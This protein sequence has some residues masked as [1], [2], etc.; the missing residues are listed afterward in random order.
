MY[1][2]KCIP[3]E[4]TANYMHQPN[5]LLK[6]ELDKLDTKTCPYKFLHIYSKQFTTSIEMILLYNIKRYGQHL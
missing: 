3:T 1:L 6:F 4:K 5:G 2:K